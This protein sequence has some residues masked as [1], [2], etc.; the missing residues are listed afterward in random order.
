MHYSDSSSIT[1]SCVL[2]VSVSVRKL[3][4]FTFTICEN[5]GGRSVSPTRLSSFD[6]GDVV[7]AAAAAGGRAG[8]GSGSLQAEALALPCP[9]AAAARPI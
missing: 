2:A 1:S 8:V 5:V 6:R 7:R 3:L 4:A 9:G